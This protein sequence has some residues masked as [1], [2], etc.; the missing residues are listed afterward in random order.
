MHDEAASVNC[1]TTG[2]LN[3]APFASPFLEK[4]T[5][6]AIGVSCMQL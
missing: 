5:V 4:G 6:G 3:K 1:D 2:G